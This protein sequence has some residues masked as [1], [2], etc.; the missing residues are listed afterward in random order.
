[1][2]CFLPGILSYLETAASVSKLQGHF[3][4]NYP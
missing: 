2:Y 1:M 4:V 3:W